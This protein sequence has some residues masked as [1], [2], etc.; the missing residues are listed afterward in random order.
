VLCGRKNDGY[1]RVTLKPIAL[2]RPLSAIILVGL[3]VAAAI[4]SLVIALP[5]FWVFAIACFVAAWAVLRHG[6]EGLF[7][8]F[9]WTLAAETMLAVLLAITGWT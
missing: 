2:V 3:G 5:Y 6:G 4:A 9:G 1:Y 8:V 7:L